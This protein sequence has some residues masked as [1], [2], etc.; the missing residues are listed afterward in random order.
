MQQASICFHNKC[1]IIEIPMHRRII[2]P[3]PFYNMEKLQCEHSQQLLVVGYQNIVNVAL[4]LS[5][6]NSIHNKTK[7]KFMNLIMRRVAAIRNKKMGILI[8]TIAIKLDLI[9]NYIGAAV[10]LQ[11]ATNIGCLLSQAALAFLL[12]NGKGALDC[13][14]NKAF[15]LAIEGYQRGCHHCKGVLA[16]CYLFSIGCSKNSTM[17]DKLAR[18]SAAMGSYYGKWM[19]SW[20]YRI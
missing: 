13:D 12:I 4:L 14:H 10:Q 11:Q 1:I 16:K 5:Q 8:H 19:L 15:A 17:S 7:F 18:E 9:R 2:I 6:S 20:W 3:I